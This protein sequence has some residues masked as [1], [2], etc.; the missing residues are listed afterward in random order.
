MLNPHTAASLL[1]KFLK[2]LPEPL[3]TWHLYDRF[4]AVANLSPPDRTK[5]LRALV[6]QLPVENRE[7]LYR[8]NSLLSAIAARAPVNKMTAANLATVVGP[9]VLYARMEPQASSNSLLGNINAANLVMEAII[10]QH[11]QIFDE[12]SAR[13]PSEV[14]SENSASLE[15]PPNNPEPSPSPQDEGRL[16]KPKEDTAPASSGS[17]TGS[18]LLTPS[19]KTS[20]LLGSYQEEKKRPGSSIVVPLGSRESLNENAVVSR[21][22]SVRDQWRQRESSSPSSE[23]IHSPRSR[24]G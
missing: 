12:A 23:N 14:T 11:A 9:T 3:L 17:S 10:S 7:L 15:P 5:E 21:L 18:A 1:K 2:Q 19:A 8:F 16:E 6:A 20:H 13:A 24:A 22:R 4:M